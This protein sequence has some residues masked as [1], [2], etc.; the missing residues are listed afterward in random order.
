MFVMKRQSSKYEAK[1]FP[2]LSNGY[3]SFKKSLNYN[4]F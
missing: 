3:N 1:S 2:K 4:V